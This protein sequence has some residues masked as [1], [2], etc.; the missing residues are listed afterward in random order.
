[1]RYEN[2]CP[3][4]LEVNPA[5]IHTCTPNVQWWLLEQ[6]CEA[7]KTQVAELEEWLEHK[8]TCYY[9]NSHYSSRGY[10]NGATT[11]EC[12]CGL[13]AALAKVKEVE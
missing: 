5:E 9:A 10:N 13:N 6:Q 7:L 3:R 11:R 1:M 8:P 2:T 12:S 4:C